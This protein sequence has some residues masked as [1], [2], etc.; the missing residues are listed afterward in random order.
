MRGPGPGSR[1]PA[2]PRPDSPVAVR[3]AA[4]GRSLVAYD[5]AAAAGGLSPC[6]ERGAARPAKAVFSVGFLTGQEVDWL[7]HVTRILRAETAALAALA[8]LVCT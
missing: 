1:S 2:R 8:Q 3:R 5:R 7:P 6:S 4:A